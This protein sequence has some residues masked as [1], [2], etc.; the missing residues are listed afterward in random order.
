MQARQPLPRQGPRTLSTLTAPCGV[1]GNWLPDTVTSIFDLNDNET[2]PLSVI[3]AWTGATTRTYTFYSTVRGGEQKAF[4]LGLN[5][6]PNDNLRFALDYQWIDIDR[7][8]SD[9]TPSAITGVTTTT[10]G[11]PVIPT[12]ST[13]QT[14]QAVALR[15]QFGF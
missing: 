6:Y 13:D 11:T 8:Q 9:A 5:W 10:T 14:V 1:H 7:L 15:A 2:S 3:T 4:T 12:L